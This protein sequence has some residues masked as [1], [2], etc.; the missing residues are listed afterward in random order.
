MDSGIWPATPLAVLLVT[1]K[2]RANNAT[3]PAACLWP[4]LPNQVP[5]DL[6]V[7]VTD[8]EE[9]TTCD[10]KWSREKEKDVRRD[11]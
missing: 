10:G 3:A 4:F 6:F 7:V 9:N 1:G 5:V 8:E 2:A 11:F